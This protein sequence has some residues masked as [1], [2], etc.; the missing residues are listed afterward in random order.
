MLHELLTITWDVGKGIPIGS[1]V[2]RYYQLLF[3]SG[4]VIG[5]FIMRGFLRKEGHP[6]ELLDKL[7]T[8]MVIATIIGARLGHVFFYQWDYYSQNPV[9]IFKVWEGGLAS[10]GAAIAIIIS[11]YFFSK[12]ESKKSTLWILDKVVVTV[13]IAG[14]LIRLGN[15]FNSEI[16][17]D[18]ANSSIQTVYSDLPRQALLRYWD[19][20]LESVEFEALGETAFTD[21][22]DY[23]VYNMKLHFHIGLDETQA[24]MLVDRQATYLNGFG[25]DDQ[26]ILIPKTENGG[27]ET[28]IEG[29]IQSGIVANV[30]VFGVPRYPTQLIESLAYLIIFFILYFM[31]Q[32]AAWKKEGLL[33][34]SFL[35]LVFG[36][37]FAVE[38]LKVV[39]VAAEEGMDFN[40]G[41]SLS[42]PLVL[43][44]IF[45]IVRSLRQPSQS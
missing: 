43:A 10:H 7:L 23:P 4:F 15:F 16:Y 29:N 31:Y 40:L 18:K 42:I 44:G 17:G 3:A 1:F 14:C 5:Y 12:K 21:S 9:D 34:G 37:R 33:F 25:D 2:L 39:Q 45:F 28:K 41:Q 27:F 26:N 30:K 8:Y 32:K 22:L 36:F 24:E 13:A 20:Q 35:V 11:M 6:D 19:Q 38:Y